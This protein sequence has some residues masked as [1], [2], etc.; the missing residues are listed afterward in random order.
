MRIALLVALVIGLALVGGASAISFAGGIANGGAVG[1]VVDLTQAGVVA[2][3]YNDIFDAQSQTLTG[4]TSIQVGLF[5]DVESANA[6]TSAYAN[7][8]FLASTNGVSF[9]QTAPL[10][11]NS[12]AAASSVAI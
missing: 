2:N 5:G 4:A 11:S 8:I 6:G 10:F 12:F 7:G 9:T 1:G 3:T